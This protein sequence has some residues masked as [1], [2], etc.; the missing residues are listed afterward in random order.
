MPINTMTHHN[1]DDDDGVD[2]DQCHD[3]DVIIMTIIVLSVGHVMFK[4]DDLDDYENF[5]DGRM[6]D[7]CYDDDRLGDSGVDTMTMV[8]MM[9]LV[10]R[11]T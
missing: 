1:N 11:T 7:T 4:H 6:L 10:R 5:D 9:T 3:G 2:D 8:I